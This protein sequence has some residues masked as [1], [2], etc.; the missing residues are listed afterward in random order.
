[1]KN[2]EADL[3]QT[4]RKRFIL[5]VAL[6]GFLICGLVI[7]DAII[8]SKED[9]MLNAVGMSGRQRSLSQRQ[10][11]LAT[12]LV[13]EIKE[14]KQN[15]ND[16]VTYPDVLKELKISRE[17]MDRSHNDLKFGS[18][19][20]GIHKP[21]DAVKRS[22]YEGEYPLD[23][24]IQDFLN[25]VEKIIKIAE[26]SF[27]TGVIDQNSID[28]LDREHA[29]IFSEAYGNL[30]NRLD[31]A[32][33]IYKEQEKIETHDLWSYEPFLLVLAIGLLVAMRR[34][35]LSPLEKT[36]YQRTKA[37]DELKKY[38]ESEKRRLDL[39]LYGTSTGIWDWDLKSDGIYLNT[40]FKKIIQYHTDNEHQYDKDFLYSIIHDDDLET[41]IEKLDAHLHHK[42]N[43]EI[44][45]RIQRKDEKWVWCKIRGQALWND[46][47]QPYKMVGSIEN[48]HAKNE[49]EKQRNI[50]VGGIEATNIPF[51]VVDLN[52]PRKN[53]AFASNAFSSLS[54]HTSDKLLNN[55]INIFTG[56]DT[57][58]SHLDQID[59][60]LNEKKSLSLKMLSYRADGRH[61]WNQITIN[62]I[63]LEGQNTCDQSAIVFED[64]TLPILREKQEIIRQR[65]ESLGALAG[66]VAHEINNLLMPMTMANDILRPELKE[67]CDPFA[68]EQLDMMVDYAGQ[69]K[70]I[71]QGILTFSRRETADLQ[72]TVLCD[73][74]DDSL[75]F[76][77][78]LLNSKVSIEFEEPEE[79]NKS[80][81]VLI[82][83][84]ELKQVITNLCKNAEQA[85]EGNSGN[86]TITMRSEK[87]TNSQRT[88]FDVIASEFLVISIA[89]NG[90][91]IPKDHLEKIF[92]PLFTTKNV[93]EGT[94]LGLSIVMGIIKSWGGAIEVESVLGKGTTF[95]LYIPI[96]K[97]E[98]D[99]SDLMDLLE[100][101]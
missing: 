94:G 71:V 27:N 31:D 22:F 92:E 11:M 72:K 101:L 33:Q 98:E 44:D 20:R 28:Q 40:V 85:F 9:S 61:F 88:K 36:I 8:L 4:I 86:I 76:I 42:V 39:A 49:A 41:F 64:L 50:L 60:A 37:L 73:E 16:F 38:H 93:G 74:I 70:E 51:A 7:I 21:F 1:M 23:Q 54:G 14:K 77:K 90:K 56:P 69:A 52:S 65:N 57:D 3:T 18:E 5:F 17:L 62:P 68:L 99:F 19:D 59:Y 80:A 79:S 89:D 48:I 10:V 12:V 83:K 34:F 13:N 2:Y 25:S 30:L 96:H 26:A 15:L 63:F 100:D 47:N 67:D 24:Q 78:G 43:F 75:Q 81:P 91:G 32:V 82:N 53:F 6:V 45:C 55:N 84:T 97:D 95:N 35:V 29:Y 66:S 58:M 46:E 87:L